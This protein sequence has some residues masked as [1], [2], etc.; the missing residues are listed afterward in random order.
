MSEGKLTKQEL[1]EDPVVTAMMQIG[2]SAKK[3]LPYLLAAV[4]L[5]VAVFVVLQVMQRSKASGERA[6]AVLVLE[7]ENQYQNGNLSEALSKFQQA[8]D[9][10]GGSRSGKLATMRTGDIQMELGNVAEA[11]A[12]YEKF[13]RASPEGGL[14]R[15]SALRGLAG[16]LES[17]GQK[18]EA[19]K[20]FL[21]AADVPDS[22][23]QFDDLLS[24][25]NAY[26][27]AG[28][29]DDAEKAFQRAI[30]EHPSHPRARDAREGLETVRAMRGGGGR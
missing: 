2:T 27:D 11:K 6:A 3:R 7:G 23:L 13:L 22:P 26:L 24:A 25:G 9:R 30:A 8:A 16:A 1:R 17:S 21:E 28:K 20:R 4:A 10:Y 29:L 5:V 14:L 15:S 18:E 12:R 19:A